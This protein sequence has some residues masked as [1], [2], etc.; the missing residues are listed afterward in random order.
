MEPLDLE[1]HYGITDRSFLDRNATQMD[2]LPDKLHTEKENN[3]VYI[4]GVFCL[5][6]THENS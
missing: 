1:V 3:K 5:A 2:L 6:F 4:Y